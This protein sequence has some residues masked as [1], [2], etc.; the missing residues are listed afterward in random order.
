M[1]Q[2]DND[3]NTALN[4]EDHAFL[5]DL[6]NGRGLFTQLGA[7]LQGP[8]RFWSY[9]IGIFMFGFFLLAVYCGWQAFHA[10]EVRETVLWSAC[11]LLLFVAMGFGKNWLFQRMNLLSLLGEMKK[12]E[13]RLAQL[14]DK[15]A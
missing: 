13:L 10:V 9:L 6:E 12:I 8:L 15:Q 11:T 2:F 1:T 7:T 4:A 5:N 3:L 14:H